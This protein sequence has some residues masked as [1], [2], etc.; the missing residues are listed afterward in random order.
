MGFLMFAIF[1]LIIGALA[2]FIMPGRDPKGIIITSVIGMVGSVLG[3]WLGRV[4]GVYNDSTQEVGWVMSLVG[5]ITLLA[6]YR[7]I[8]GRSLGA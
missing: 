6:I 5:A 1:G 4:T 2:R 8:A 7:V 3:G